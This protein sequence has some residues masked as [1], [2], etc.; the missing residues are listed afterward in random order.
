MCVYI[1]SLV[2]VT[3]PPLSI[4]M[5]MLFLLLGELPIRDSASENRNWICVGG[6]QPTHAWPVKNDELWAMS[7]QETDTSDSSE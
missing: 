7:P 6:Q 5:P 4:P 2:V 3:V 1:R